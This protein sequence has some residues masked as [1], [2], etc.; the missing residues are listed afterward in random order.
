MDMMRPMQFNVATTVPTSPVLSVPVIGTGIQLSWIDATPPSDPATWGNPANEIGFRIERTQYDASGKTLGAYAAIGTALA[1]ATSFTDGVTA[2]PL[3]K[4][5]YRIIAFNVAG[6]TAS[7]AVS[8]TTPGGPV[9]PTGLAAALQA[10][11]QVT[12]TW[13]DN[14]TNETGYVV[15][16]SVNGGAYA[17]LATPAAHPGTG[18]MTYVDLTAL[19]GNSYAYR[20]FAVNGVIRSILSNTATVV[21]PPVP[22][23]P[24]GLAAVLQV[25][26][27]VTLTWTDNATNETG[28]VVQRSVNGGAMATIATPAAHTG[29]GTMTYTDLTV[30]QGNTYAYTVYAVNGVIA[31]ALSNTA[32]VTVAPPPAAPT[33][34]TAALQATLGVAPKIA[35]TFKDNATNETGFVVERAVNAGAFATLAMLPAK[36]GTV[37]YADTTVAAGNSYTYRVRAVNGAIVSA[38][39][40]TPAAVVIPPLPAAPSNFT[41]TP[42]T[43][44]RRVDLKWTDNSNNETGFVIQRSMTATFATFTNFNVAANATTLTQTGLVSGTIYY[45]RIMAQNLYGQS[46]WVNTVPLSVTV[47]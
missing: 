28:F 29:T 22:L 44:T 9:A 16:R 41:A 8:V 26:P 34:L 32:S 31:S 7:N 19:P 23:A 39:S 25:G 5:S 27:Q 17:T 45:Y 13:T 43:K 24:S 40:N 37:T 14:A 20:V 36:T 10:G 30:A 47:P 42:G 4:Y 18:T 38:Y 33:S 6:E 46:A 21:V 11:P 15:Q 2:A 12:L 1:N 3:T 35:L